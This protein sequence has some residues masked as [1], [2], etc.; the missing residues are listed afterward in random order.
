LLAQRGIYCVC[1]VRPCPR[2]RQGCLHFLEIHSVANR[3]L[4]PNWYRQFFLRCIPLPLSERFL[5]QSHCFHRFLARAAPKVCTKP[6]HDTPAHSRTSHYEAIRNPLCHLHGFPQGGYEY[7]VGPPW[8]AQTDGLHAQ[9]GVTL[10]P[11]PPQ[12]TPSP[13]LQAHASVFFPKGA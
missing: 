3:V 10:A 7:C 13:R 4:P 6:L 9:L 12:Q 11:L 1:S 5:Y 8:G 2:E